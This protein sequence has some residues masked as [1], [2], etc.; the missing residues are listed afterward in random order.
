MLDKNELNELL[1]GDRDGIFAKLRRCDYT[2]DE[3]QLD[4]LREFAKELNSKIRSDRGDPK[5][6]LYIVA[7]VHDLFVFSDHA[8]WTADFATEIYETVNYMVD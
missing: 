3:K 2:K 8:D 1:Y 6:V 5:D 4:L 7:I